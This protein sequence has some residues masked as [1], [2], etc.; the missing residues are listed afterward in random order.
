MA[1]KLDGSPLAVD[2]AFKTSDGTQYPA[3][4]LRLSSADEKK[5]L[6]LLRLLTIQYMTHVFI[7]VME[8]QK[9]LQIQMKL[10]RMVSIIR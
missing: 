5:P 8:L 1:F 3:N 7:G 10:M 6:V 2:V 9:H 4:W